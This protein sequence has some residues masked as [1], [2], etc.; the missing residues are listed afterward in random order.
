MD[1]L[2]PNTQSINSWVY[3][4][5]LLD[6]ADDLCDLLDFTTS[7][8]MNEDDEWYSLLN[9]TYKVVLHENARGKTFES[10]LAKVLGVRAYYQ[11]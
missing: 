5:T 9:T 4:S 1:V 7:I 11:V 2:K 8:K 10:T 3:F 6:Y